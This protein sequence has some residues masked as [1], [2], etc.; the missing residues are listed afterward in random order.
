M[1]VRINEETFSSIK[2]SSSGKF[3]ARGYVTSRNSLVVGVIGPNS[4]LKNMVHIT[5]AYL[6][7]FVTRRKLT[8]RVGFR[9]TFD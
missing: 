3:V 2:D 9:H 7:V 1:H 6:L 5:P 8:K 4:L